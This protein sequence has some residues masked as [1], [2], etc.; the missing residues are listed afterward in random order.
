MVFIIAGSIVFYGN[1]N[2]NNLGGDTFCIYDDLVQEVGNSWWEDGCAGGPQEYCGNGTKI[3]GGPFYLPQ[4]GFP[5]PDN[6]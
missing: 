2:T 4:D 3:N 6:A 5:Y 1:P